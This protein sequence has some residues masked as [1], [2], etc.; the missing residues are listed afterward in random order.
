MYSE[1]A[2]SEW[3]CHR[4]FARFHH[5]DFSLEDHKLFGRPATMD[6]RQIVVLTEN[7]PCYPT[8]EIA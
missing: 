2:V 7:N 3:M 4:Q 5:G 6:D 1:D 8:F